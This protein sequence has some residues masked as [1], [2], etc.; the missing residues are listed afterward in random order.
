MQLRRRI[1]P[2]TKNVSSFDTV[3]LIFKSLS[4]ENV[5]VMVFNKFAIGNKMPRQSNFPA[6]VSPK[7]IV[8]YFLRHRVTQRHRYNNSKVYVHRN[9][10]TIKRLVM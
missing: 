1:R 7:L 10:S 9:Q 3:R 2:Y 6:L 5:L 4:Q 8:E